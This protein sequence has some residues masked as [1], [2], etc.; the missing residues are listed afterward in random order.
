MAR[1]TTTKIPTARERIIARV[2]Q[3]GIGQRPLAARMGVPVTT[4]RRALAD[5]GLLTV[6]RVVE[7]ARALD[8]TPEELIPEL[9]T[10][11]EPGAVTPDAILDLPLETLYALAAETYNAPVDAARVLTEQR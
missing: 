10:R 9:G 4:M 5:D 1:S 7:F 8:V 11:R 3:A 6:R 2:E